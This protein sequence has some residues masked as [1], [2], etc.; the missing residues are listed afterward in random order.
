MTTPS[1]GAIS[2]D[3]VR[4]ELGRSG[5]ISFGDTTVRELAFVPGVAAPR[6]GAIGLADMRGRTKYPP[7]ATHYYNLAQQTFWADSNSTG[8]AVYEGSLTS[9]I[10]PQLVG[11]THALAGAFLYCRGTYVQDI[12]DQFNRPEST[13]NFYKIQS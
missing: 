1:T 3:Q 5:P 12:Q 6:S 11:A 9:S 13:Y 8:A 4:S 2:M 10:A 7:G